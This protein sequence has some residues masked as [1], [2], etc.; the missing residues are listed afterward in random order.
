MN[1]KTDNEI[2]MLMER[3]FEGRTTL[4]E[5]QEL[6]GFFRKEN[7]PQDL[8]PYKDMFLDFSALTLTGQEAALLSPDKLP[9]QPATKDITARPAPIRQRRTRSIYLKYSMGIAATLLLAVLIGWGV[10]TRQERQLAA[11]YEGSYMIVNGKRTDKLTR[12][13]PEIERTL[14]KAE[15]IEQD[16]SAEALIQTAE[17]E[18]LNGIEDEAERERIRQLME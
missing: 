14:A 2:R 11:L 10:N 6:Y 17:E 18:I 1:A 13:H 5:E 7:L 12:I 8:L 9:S 16:L 3:F 4:E 15:K